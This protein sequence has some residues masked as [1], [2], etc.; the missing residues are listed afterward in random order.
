MIKPGDTTD[1]YSIHPATVIDVK[2]PFVVVEQACCISGVVHE[3]TIHICN[4]DSYQ[5]CK[6]GKCL[7]DSD[8]GWMFHKSV[9]ADKKRTGCNSVLDALEWMGM[10]NDQDKPIR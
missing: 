5:C 1:I 9:Y 7:T 10:D 4:M 2:M 3:I 8:K 6:T